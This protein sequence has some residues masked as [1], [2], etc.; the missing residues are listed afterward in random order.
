VRDRVGTV[1]SGVFTD[2]ADAG[3]RLAD[4]LTSSPVAPTLVAP[5]VLALPRGGVPVAV[6]VA[7]AIGADLDVV[8][9]RKLG[10]PGRSELA[11]GAIGEHGV[12]VVNRSVVEMLGVS[13]RAF[14][15]VEHQEREELERRARTYRG[16]RPPLPVANRD[17]VLV[18][19]GLAT[20]STARAA[21]EVVRVADAARVFLAVPVAPPDTVQTLRAV[22]DDVIAVEQ[23]AQ[24][25]A[26]GSWYRDF[27]QTSD[28]EVQ[29]LL[30]GGSG[31]AS[32]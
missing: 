31:D 23:P 7:Q 9:V 12:R 2:R 24:L 10:V 21:I 11:M 17:V 32:G 3:R 22:A 16:G 18:D 4:A 28:A 13:D 26:I 1:T 30:Q 27:S 20:G 8:L 29:R 25:W 5:A 19:D 6:P 14:A 15:R